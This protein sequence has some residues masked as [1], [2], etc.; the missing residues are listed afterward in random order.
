MDYARKLLAMICKEQPYE[1][2]FYEQYTQGTSA[3]Q[4]SY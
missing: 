4:L 2:D 3:N 1:N